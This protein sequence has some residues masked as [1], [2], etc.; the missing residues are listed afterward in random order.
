MEQDIIYTTGYPYVDAVQN[1]AN[2]K[3]NSSNLDKQD[4]TINIVSKSCSIKTSLVPN[5]KPKL[6]DSVIILDWFLNEC[7]LFC[8]FLPFF[9]L[10]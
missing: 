7:D 1:Y 6:D 5:K 2:N 10:N 8:F 3:K 4:K 9:L